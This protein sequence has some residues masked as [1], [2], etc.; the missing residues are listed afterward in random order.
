MSTSAFVACW[1]NPIECLKNA[2]S[3][4]GG[5]DVLS[6]VSPTDLSLGMNEGLKSGIAAGQIR[7]YGVDPDTGAL[8]APQY[9]PIAELAGYDPTNPQAFIDMI[10]A[11]TNSQF[12]K[13]FAD[14][15]A[16]MPL[17]PTVP[18]LP[19]LSDGTNWLVIGV[20]VVLAFLLIKVV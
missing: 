6:T 16:S 20:I 1:S 8:S 14:N 12:D 15:L 2:F 3:D 7:A 9:A 10:T 4:P 5:S 17:L 19:D 13:Q 11:Q 18:G